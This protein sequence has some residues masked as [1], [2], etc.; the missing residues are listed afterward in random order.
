MSSYLFTLNNNKYEA[1]Y[2]GECCDI[3]KNDQLL[4]SGWLSYAM[5]SLVDEGFNKK[6]IDEIYQKLTS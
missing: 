5:D 2:D 1:Y 3:H 4:S 6:Q